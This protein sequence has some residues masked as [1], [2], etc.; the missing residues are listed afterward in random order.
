MVSCGVRRAKY[1]IVT[2]AVL[3]PGAGNRFG[4][5][6]V[7]GQVL[8]AGAGAGDSQVL[9]KYGGGT[10]YGKYTGFGYRGNLSF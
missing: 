4:A 2:K 7:Q 6:L 1:G 10:H 9:G 8:S 5:G 3:V